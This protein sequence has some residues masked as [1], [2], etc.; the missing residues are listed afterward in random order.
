MAT[1]LSS[2]PEW[3]SNK[4]VFITGGTGFMGKVLIFKL[5]LSCPDIG[6]IF[7]LIRRKKGIDSQ[8][9]LNLILQVCIIYHNKLPIL[10]V[11]IKGNKMSE[12]L[13]KRESFEVKRKNI[14]CIY[15]LYTK[16]NNYMKLIINCNIFSNALN[17]SQ[18]DLL[19]II[20]QNLKYKR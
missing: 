15:S 11:H 8:A 5:L 13:K 7:L 3:F 12:Y 6:D 17:T 20:G 2:I 14:V 1:K 9:R 18:Y 19:H 10:F 4:S 16:T